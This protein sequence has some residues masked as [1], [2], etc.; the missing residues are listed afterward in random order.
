MG[1][2]HIAARLALL[3]ALAG[4][5]W[6]PPNPTPVAQL[7]LTRFAGEWFEVARI[8]NSFEDEMG[9]ACVEARVVY[10]LREDGRLSISSICRD[11]AHGGA[12]VV[13]EGTA[14]P[15]P[16]GGR[17]LATFRWPFSTPYWVLG[18]DPDYRWAVLGVPSR[19]YLWVLARTPNLSPE[20]EAS[21][22]AVAVVQGYDT[23]LLVKPGAP[24]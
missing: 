20:D 17:L 21:A 18:I 5:T 16:A 4:C 13:V 6:P 12:T 22:H 3:L 2:W 8:P 10:V 11:A 19:R 1:S 23:K 7:D 15:D 24:K 14:R 9:R